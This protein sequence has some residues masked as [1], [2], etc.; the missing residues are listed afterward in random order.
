[1]NYE[2]LAGYVQEFISSSQPLDTVN[3]TPPTK[4]GGFF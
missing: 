4:V 2:E 1:M 3:D